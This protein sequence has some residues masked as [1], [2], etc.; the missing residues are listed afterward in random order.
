MTPNTASPDEQRRG[1]F[2]V[3]ERGT[4]L[5]IGYRL[6]HFSDANEGLSIRS[7]CSCLGGNWGGLEGWAWNCST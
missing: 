4:I 3:F 5:D 1:V 7:D 2:F 6:V